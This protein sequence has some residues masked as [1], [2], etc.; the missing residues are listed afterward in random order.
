MN[1][2]ANPAT[3]ATPP[4]RNERKR[5]PMSVPQQKLEVPDVPG[6]HRHW[7]RE[8][9]VARAIQGG[10]EF[11]QAKDA[12][13]NQKGIGTAP[14]VSGNMDLGSHIRV[15]SGVG[16]DGHAEWLVLME[17]REEWWLEDQAA[18]AARNA[19]TMSAIFRGETIPGS[20]PTGTAEDQSLVYVSKALFN[21]PARKSAK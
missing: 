16:E 17:I 15:S 7:F 6:M 2:P 9:R 4:S 21:R 5:I 11:V 8:N 14:G 18:I 20:K 13:L 19:Q 1:T 10:Y 3:Q 12:P